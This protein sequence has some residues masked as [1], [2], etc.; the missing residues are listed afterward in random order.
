MTLIEVP[1]RT[2]F[3]ALIRWVAAEI[4][5]D[6]RRRDEWA[7]DAL[8]AIPAAALTGDVGASLAELANRLDG[9]I[10]VFDRTGHPTTTIGSIRL[11]DAELDRITAEA[12]RFLTAGRRAGGD[13]DLELG[14][15]TFQTLGPG[16]RLAGVL[17]VLTAARLDRAARLVLNAA[18]ALLE[19]SSYHEDRARELR[20][21]LGDRAVAFIGTG[22][23]DLARSLIA[24]T[25][26]TL[27]ADP[28]VVMASMFETPARRDAA[29]TAMDATGALTGATGDELL[30]IASGRAW[31]RRAERMTAAG[32][33]SGV[34]SGV[35]W[36]DAGRAFDRARSALLRTTAANPV[37]EW[38]GGGER[39]L[40]AIVSSPAT[41]AYA[42]AA[43]EAAMADEQ[44]AELLRYAEVWLAHD[45]HWDASA[46]ALGVHRHTLKDRIRRLGVL[47]GLDLET[48]GGKV[49]LHI[50]LRAAA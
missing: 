3:L 6:A 23:H 16:G 48:F 44:G 22:D 20:S 36:A 19:V 43:I 18:V 25:G 41:A 49:E 32:G 14:A 9:S 24:A 10:L 5:R 21:R 35:R 38:D 1:Y 17:V 34:V 42:H 29:R 12:R 13:L 39:A 45:G 30:T 26:G 8:R 15:A 40:D 37:A 47:L 46:R 11:P 33:R 7:L 31:H 2:P 28:L 27:P 4:E 50:L